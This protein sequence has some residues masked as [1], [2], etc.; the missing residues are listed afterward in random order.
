VERVT[1]GVVGPFCFSWV[2]CPEALR[3]A[4]APGSFVASFSLD[5]AAIDIAADRD[6]DPF[7]DLVVDRLSPEARLGYERARQR[8]GYRVF[9][10][11]KFVVTPEM[12]G[13]LREICEKQRTRNVVYAV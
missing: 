3:S 9:K 12:V 13:P 2:R 1:K 11:R 7:E 8:Y 10:D 6:N 5:I 4:L